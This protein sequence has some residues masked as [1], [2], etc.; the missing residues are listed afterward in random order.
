MGDPA[1]AACNRISVISTRSSERHALD[2]V[3][4]CIGGI[5]MLGLPVA[6][7]W[8]GSQTQRHPQAC[9]GQLR[10]H[11]PCQ[12]CVSAG[13]RRQKYTQTA[14]LQMCC[15]PYWPCMTARTQTWSQWL[16]GDKGHRKLPVQGKQGGGLVLLDVR[17]CQ[18]V[19]GP[20]FGCCKSAAP[21]YATR[22]GS[23]CQHSDMS[24]CR[25]AQPIMC[26]CCHMEPCLL[27]PLALPC[28]DM[29]L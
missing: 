5:R 12:G 7:G 8:S 25:H 9:L 20:R 21:D 6:S 13:S 17:S 24:T 11:P 15:R 26:T 1:H 2:G 16:T 3:T 4:W 19:M 14:D 29:C 23:S 27:K 28:L 10:H 22:R 18:Q